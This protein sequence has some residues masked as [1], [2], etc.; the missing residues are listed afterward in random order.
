MS[1][2]NCSQSRDPAARGTEGH[3]V[4]PMQRALGTAWDRLA[5][6]LQAHHGP[7][8]AT[9][10]GFM[11]I[12]YPLFMQPVV[13]VL[14]HLGVLVKRRGRQVQTTVVKQMDG[15]RQHWRRTLRFAD[16][17]EICFNSIW[18]PSGPGR[19]IEY[20][21]PFLGLEMQPALVGSQI[22]YR[23]LRFVLQI[24]NRML[25]VPQGLGP[26]VT[27][28]IEEALD[29]RRFVMDFRMTHPW[30]GQTFRYAG[31]FVTHAAAARRVPT[32]S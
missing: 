5:P 16:G 17:L 23:G 31:T 3:P 20:V 6:A 8:Q 24:G 11:D 22:H 25:S 29:E 18:V 21:N 4:S 1:A 9:D 2:S 10:E 30:F 15:E 14:G 12:D 32:A 13:S 7:E 28:I 27:R 26:G 19:F